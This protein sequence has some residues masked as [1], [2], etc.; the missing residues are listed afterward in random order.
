MIDGYIYGCEGGPEKGSGSLRCLDVVTGE[1][2]WEE[3]LR[4]I[5][6][7]LMAAG[8]KLIILNGKGDLHIPKF[9]YKLFMR[10]N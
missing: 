5:T 7:S 9:C 8:G 2:M 3:D 6:M 4:G 10:N 1:V